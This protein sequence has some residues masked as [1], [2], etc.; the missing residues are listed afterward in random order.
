MPLRLRTFKI[1][2]L[3]YSELG[4]FGLEK[5]LSSRSGRKLEK[6]ESFFLF[7][8]LHLPFH[9]LYTG[10][11]NKRINLKKREII[12]WSSLRL[13]TIGWRVLAWSNLVRS[14]SSLFTHRK[15]VSTVFFSFK[16]SQPASL[17]VSPADLLTSFLALRSEVRYPPVCL[18]NHRASH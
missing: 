15:M 10:I 2:I 7:S 14:I 11:I 5:N 18:L 3:R 9:I 6:N 8:A 4:F 16:P 17:Q 12:Y 13:T 1:I